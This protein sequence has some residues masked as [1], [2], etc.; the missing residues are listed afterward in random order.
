MTQRTIEQHLAL[1]LRDL[2][3]NMYIS[4]MKK[5]DDLKRELE[6]LNLDDKTEII[7]TPDLGGINSF[8]LSFDMPVYIML[9]HPICRFKSQKRY[10]VNAYFFIA[11]MGLVPVYFASINTMSVM[12][13]WGEKTEHFFSPTN[14]PIPENE[15]TCWELSNEGKMVEY[16]TMNFISTQG[17][18]E[19]LAPKNMLD[20]FEKYLKLTYWSFPKKGFTFST[21]IFHTRDKITSIMKVA[22]SLYVIKKIIGPPKNIPVIE[23]QKLNCK[24]CYLNGLSKEGNSYFFT[25]FPV[26]IEEELADKIIDSKKDNYG[27][28]NGMVTEVRQPRLTPYGTSL[29]KIPILTVVQDYGESYSDL[30]QALIGIICMS[31]HTENKLVSFV[32]KLDDIKKEVTEIFHKIYLYVD[33][34]TSVADIITN[35]FTDLVDSMFPLFVIDKDEVFYTHPLFI[36]YLTK[37]GITLETMEKDRKILTCF[38]RLADKSI[39]ENGNSSMNLY[40]S[41]E[42]EYLCSKGI[43]KK[44]IF[45]DIGRISDIIKISKILKKMF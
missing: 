23:G 15:I 34:K 43:S 11:N 19:N 8:R 41:D 7:K 6:N 35:N 5:V 10:P 16:S 17:S 4:Y 29:E 2:D 21:H 39:N 1:L 14:I 24:L 18:T 3:R 33:L 22:K 31:R 25:E 26:L 28:I 30:L 36:T 12:R 38:L 44:E 32:G 20:V 13:I 9:S 27:F 42:A 45:P 40:L 37:C